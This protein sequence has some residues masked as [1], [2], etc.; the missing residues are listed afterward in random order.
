MGSCET[1]AEGTA[2]VGD[3]AGQSA[4]RLY[5]LP[6]SYPPLSQAGQA[7]DW[8]AVLGRARG[9]GFN[10]V[11]L[12]PIFATERDPFLVT[13][14]E[15]A[16][17]ALGLA[18]S[19]DEA[20]AKLAALCRAH[21]VRL[22]LDIVLDRLSATGESARNSHG[23]YHPG[24]NAE[25]VDP[26]EPGDMAHSAIVRRGADEPLGQWWGERLARLAR[27]GVEGFRLVG[28]QRLS[29][30]AV[31]RIVEATRAQVACR[32]WAWT[33]ALDW[34][35]HAGL[36]AARLDGVFASTAWWDGRGDWYVNEYE[37]LRC[38]APVLGVAEA[39]FRNPPADV[40]SRRRMLRLAALTGD[41][42]LMPA[43]F[44]CDLEDEVKRVNAES[45]RLT[46]IACAGE[47]RRLTETAAP[48]A[49]L[50]RLDAPAPEA[51]NGVAV[52]INNDP[53][54]AR[55]VGVSLDPLDPAG[56]A[57][58]GDP[59]SVDGAPLLEMLGPG[60]I[61]AVVLRHIGAVREPRRQERR[62]ANAAA[63]R[64]PL[65]IE[66]VTPQVAGGPFAVKRV[67]GRSIVV[68]ADVFAD[69]HDLLAA[70]LLW[71]AA[72]EK[73]W[74][75][76]RMVALGND[77]W[78]ATMMPKRIGRHLFSIEAWRD[79]YG[80]LCHALEVKHRAGIDVS[81]EIADA[82]A[83]IGRLQIKTLLS[84]LTAL[85][86]DKSVERLTSREARAL[87]AESDERAFASQHEAIALDVER[88]QAEFASWYEL[89]PRSI[90]TFDDVVGALP[91]I[92][93]MGFDV[94]YFPPIHS[95]GKTNRKGR[96]N[97][98]TP[99]PDD[100]GS[101]YAIG[102]AE[103]GHDAIHPALGT[104]ESFRRLVAAARQQGL[105]IAIDFAIQCSPDHPWLKEH[106]E[107]FRHR[108]DGSIRY[109]ENPPKK[110]ED[111]VNV[112][113]Y[114]DGAVP[115]L[116][117]ALRN[118]VLHWVDEGVKIFRVDNPHTKP[119][120]FWEWMIAD[121]R[122][123]H[124]D[125]MFLAEAFTRPTMMY[126]LGK[127]GFSQS[128]T[129]FTWRN[130]KAELSDY[131]RELAT[132]DVADY[133]R[134]NLFVNTPDINPYFLQSSGRA[135]FLIRACLAT[136]LSGLWGMY[137]GF[138][139]CESAPLPGREEYLDSE[140]YEVRRRDFN[141]PG[142]IVGEI[143]T[144]NRLRRSH[145]ALQSH[146]GLTFYNAFNDQVMVYGKATAA[147]QDM[148]LVA[149]S[150]DPHHVQEASFEVPLWEWQ[151]PDDGAVEVEDLMRG[152]RFV[153]HG[154]VQR[155]RLDPADLPFAIWRIAP[156]GGRP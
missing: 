82:K 147:Y 142:N 84:E 109:A 122:A 3:S 30:Q 54:Q 117:L 58:L 74:Q 59:R 119:L 143:S 135:G 73:D 124:P 68:E 24:E 83:Y 132:T 75:R 36:K 60:E 53:S 2:A 20:T 139:L 18:A 66:R 88:P 35:R 51:R 21:G 149:V 152:H 47:M 44:E 156:A 138:E 16:N 26:R 92:R 64:S 17:A 65:V 81:L 70:E 145:P 94:L 93:D 49:A 62:A 144:L 5:Y 31:Q 134:P 52:L 25:V 91:R 148:V 150:L 85:D 108:A 151:M 141:A 42:F 98:L 127:I 63:A 43:G 10:A 55:P 99:G 79:E 154:K 103:G 50:V 33:A 137:S 72:D 131:M 87:V 11:A 97:A 104:P 110:Y 45:E 105:E 95:I 8:S 116:W 12:P 22:V 107:W 113:F 38:A 96:N 86:V 100:P 111:I 29:N 77:R 101:P 90:G 128:Y 46:T 1:S 125:T 89:F 13:D 23:L 48:V 28:L 69:G 80:S 120:P 40:E 56:G 130:S 114:A 123:R 118:I 153:W 121:V 7:P 19:A 6:L 76:V 61:R 39:P 32:F 115:D 34:G 129:Y 106:P 146:R 140:K 71:R 155:V 133:Y 102:S 78:R 112:D 9:L 67:I 4:A 57:V 37:S 136:T 27:V 15:A 14:L 126:R 41:G